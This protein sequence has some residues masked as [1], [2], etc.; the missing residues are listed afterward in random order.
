MD[1][2]RADNSTTDEASVGMALKYYI[3]I[4]APP[5]ST[6]DWKITATAKDSFV[7]L[8]SVH[9]VEYGWGFPC[10]DQDKINQEIAFTPRASN[11]DEY[12][13]AELTLKKLTNVGK[14]PAL[15]ATCQSFPK[16]DH[17]DD[18]YYQMR[19]IL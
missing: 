17:M 11:E 1:A 15:L 3:I 13:V 6:A 18:V 16:T 4:K 2:W 14:Y 8:C 19:K 9:V 5:T 7:R 12:E 10:M